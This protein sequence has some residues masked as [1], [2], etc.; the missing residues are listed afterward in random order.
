[1]RVAALVTGKVRVAQQPVQQHM[2]LGEWKD[3][4]N[5][6]VVLPCSAFFGAN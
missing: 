4:T 6:G 5:E 2:L 3:R 1:M